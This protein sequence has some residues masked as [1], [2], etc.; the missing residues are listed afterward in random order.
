MGKLCGMVPVNLG[1]QLLVGA[2]LDLRNGR[3]L[4]EAEVRL[5][6][7]LEVHD[8]EAHVQ[9]VHVS[10]VH[11]SEVHVPEALGYGVP[12]QEVHY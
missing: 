10:E 6:I 5:E 4:E 8:L 12:A 3:R 2:P 9:G 11:V 1:A 7:D